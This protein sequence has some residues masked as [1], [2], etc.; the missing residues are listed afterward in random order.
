MGYFDGLVDGNFKLLEDG[1][2]L[3]VP[4]SPFGKG[5]IIPDAQRAQEIRTSLKRATFSAMLILV[6]SAGL[7]FS[8]SSDSILSSWLFWT[9]YTLICLGV[10]FFANAK[11]KESTRGLTPTN[12]KISLLE[13]HQITAQSFG[14]PTLWMLLILSL[15]MTFAAFVVLLNEHGEWYLRLVG[16]LAWLL[17][18][19]GT[20][21]SGYFMGLKGRAKG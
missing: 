19:L 21:A 13:S 8:V 5:Y 20:I 17:G 3:F 10:F 1:T 12:Q 4:N 18:G 14:M 15:L 7:L 9:I 6:L 11:I 2:T 16:L